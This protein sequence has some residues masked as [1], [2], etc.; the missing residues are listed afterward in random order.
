MRGGT[1]NERGADPRGQR[2]SFKLPSLPNPFE[3]L[4]GA[5]EKKAAPASD[6]GGQDSE[7]V[8]GRW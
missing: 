4:T 6:S 8:W 1:G 2:F 7:T 5:N 3:N